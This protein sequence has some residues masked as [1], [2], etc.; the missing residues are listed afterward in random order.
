[1]EKPALYASKSRR[2]L[3]SIVFMRKKVLNNEV[4]ILE[5]IIVIKYFYKKKQY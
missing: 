4:L 5:K 3:I 1:M 2:T